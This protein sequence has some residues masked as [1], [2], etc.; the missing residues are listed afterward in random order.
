MPQK[1]RY[2]ARREPRPQ[3][4]IGPYYAPRW[5]IKK[6]HTRGARRDM[7][8][9]SASDMLV[10]S[11]RLQDTDAARRALRIPPGHAAIS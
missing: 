11:R 7:A 6:P 4:T 9:D 5:R 10:I 3:S 1:L 2:R 8:I